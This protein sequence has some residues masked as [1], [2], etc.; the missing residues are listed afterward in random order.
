MATSP[1]RIRDEDK[2]H[3]ERLRRDIAATTGRKPSQ[4]ETLGKTL[5]F[6]LR[7]RDAFLAEAAWKPLRPA[8]VAFW[9]R[10]A[11]HLGAW[12]SGDIDAIVYGEAT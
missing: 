12:A 3:L 8:D 6:A 5:D 10:Q 9:R 2:E 1:V 11:E 4:Q 7:H